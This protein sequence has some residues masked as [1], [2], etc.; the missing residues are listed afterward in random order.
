MHSEPSQTSRMGYFVKIVNGW[1]L[2]N[3]FAKKIH[4]RCLIG[5]WIRLDIVRGLG[6]AYQRL[7]NN[8]GRGVVKALQKS[9]M[10]FFCKNSGRL[11]AV[12]YF[13]KNLYL[14]MFNR[15]LIHL[16]FMKTCRSMGYVTE[17]RRSKN[18]LECAKCIS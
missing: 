3:I 9:N 15:V 14:K 7:N 4:L 13:R 6:I 16:W 5:F 17:W 8:M 1:K 2:L 10:E 11:E 18:V 12:N